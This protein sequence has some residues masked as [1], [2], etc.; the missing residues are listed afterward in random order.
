MAK[1]P[2]L[3]QWWRAPR[4]GYVSSSFS[5]RFFPNAYRQLSRGYKELPKVISK[6]I[7]HR[8]L[9]VDRGDR[10]DLVQ[11]RPPLDTRSGKTWLQ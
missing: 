1:I 3:R 5:Y 9:E 11:H 8:K 2:G 10:P 6:K 4:V 7:G